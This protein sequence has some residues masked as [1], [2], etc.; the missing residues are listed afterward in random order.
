LPLSFFP[1]SP[2][3]VSPCLIVP[4]CGG[5]TP[6]LVVEGIIMWFCYILSIKA[7]MV[8]QNNNQKLVRADSIYRI[9]PSKKQKGKPSKTELPSWKTISQVLNWH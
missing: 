2:I 6:C 7:T 5:E 8:C 3:S 9:I 1:L 4:D